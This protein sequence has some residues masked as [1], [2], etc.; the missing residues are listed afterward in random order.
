MKKIVK[1]I[2]IFVVGLLSLSLT[3]CDSKVEESTNMNIVTTIFPAYDFARA[4]VGDTA[5]LTM[6]LKPGVESHNYDPTPKDIIKIQKSDIF[7]YNGGESEEWVEKILESLDTSKMTI[8]KMMDYVETKEE[9]TVEGMQEEEEEETS[10]EEIEYDEHIWTSPVNAIKIVKAI[11]DKIVKTDKNNSDL[12]ESN[13]SSYIEELESINTSFTNIVKDAKRKELV[14]GDR[15]PLRYFV[16][17]YELKYSAAFPGCASEVE[18]S[19]KTIAFLIDKVNE[20]KI[21]VIFYIELSNQKVADSIKESTNVKTLLFHSCHNVTK[22]DFDS[23]VT[24]VDLMKK[25]V[26]NLKE[27]LN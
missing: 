4:V 17:E 6:L 5:D 23:G 21:P 11:K 2:S 9:E 27:A 14:F 13:A 26:P 18:P 12:Y 19:A 25:N 24:Y 10:E 3:G 1:I 16:D 7:I 8:I 22:E 20:E 15:F